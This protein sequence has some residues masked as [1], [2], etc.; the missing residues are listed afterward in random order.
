[1]WG[2]KIFN[3]ERS[4][5]TIVFKYSFEWTMKNLFLNRSCEKCKSF[6]GIYWN[7]F[8]K[9][10]SILT[11]MSEF[12]VPFQKSRISFTYLSCSQVAHYLTLLLTTSSIFLSAWTILGPIAAPG[13]T[14][15]ALLVLIV[16]ALLGGQI[17]KI[18][19]SILSKLFRVNISLPPLLGTPVRNPSFSFS[20]LTSTCQT[21]FLFNPNFSF[22]NFT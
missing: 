18:F 3:M 19:G 10:E 1:M 14:V 4:G 5:D 8:T 15:F 12:Y 6:N 11:L 7:L 16:L 9:A 17:I 21:N 2:I 20:P 13:G 22:S